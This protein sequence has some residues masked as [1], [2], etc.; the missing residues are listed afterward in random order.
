MKSCPKCQTS[1]EDGAQ[2][3]PACGYA[4]VYSPPAQLAHAEP[5]GSSQSSERSGT[6]G[7][8][9]NK[10]IMAMA[11]DALQ[12]RWGLAIGGAVIYMLISF[13]VQMV[14]YLGGIAMLIIGGPLYLGFF[15]FFLTFSR[16]E[17]P[18]IG[19]LFD[20]FSNFGTAVGTYLLMVLFIF[21]WMLLLIV[22]GIIAAIAYSQVFFILADKPDIGPMQALRESK[23]MM[24][25]YKAKYFLLGLRFL[26][27]ALLCILTLGIGFLWYVPYYQTSIA[28][29]YDDLAPPAPAEH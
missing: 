22:P 5:I 7:V 28:K 25:G 21:L 4:F 11:R 18:A 19:R 1:I 13:A 6:G 23:E 17:D 27:W 24:D 8:T 3:C 2:F 9:S 29:F 12:G 16:G 26:G 15:M 20:G 14:P 10:D